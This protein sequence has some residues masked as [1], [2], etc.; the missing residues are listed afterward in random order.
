VGAV[1]GGGSSS[2]SLSMK[3]LNTE[4]ASDLSFLSFSSSA[5]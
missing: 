4:T 1:G 3:V 5:S 2:P